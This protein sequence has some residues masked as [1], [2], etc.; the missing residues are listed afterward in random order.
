MRVR[1]ADQEIHHPGVR[2]VDGGARATPPD[3][4]MHTW[5][6]RTRRGRAR[7][8]RAR[9]SAGSGVGGIPGGNER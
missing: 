3:G 7:A 1:S 9:R 2:T 8:R 5:Q 4:A 6:A